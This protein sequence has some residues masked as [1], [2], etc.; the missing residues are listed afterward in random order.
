MAKF[1]NSQT[2]QYEKYLRGQLLWEAV[3]QC[4]CTSGEKQRKAPAPAF[5]DTPTG[6]ESATTEFGSIN[7]SLSGMLGLV[8]NHMKYLSTIFQLMLMIGIKNTKPKTTSIWNR[9]PFLKNSICLE[10]AFNHLPLHRFPS[11]PPPDF[12]FI[13]RDIFCT[14]GD[15]LACDKC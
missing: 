13:F 7:T 5:R 15:L 4:S 3:S 8:L 14:T 2:L 1:S 11:P 10:K 9:G 6:F 12:Y